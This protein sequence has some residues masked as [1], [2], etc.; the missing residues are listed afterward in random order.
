MLESAKF[1]IERALCFVRSKS[2]LPQPFGKYKSLTRVNF[3][4]DCLPSFK[5]SDLQNCDVN[6]KI[7]R[8]IKNVVNSL[9]FGR[10]WK[11]LNQVTRWGQ[12]PESSRIGNIMFRFTFAIV[13]K[14][15]ETAIS[16]TIWSTCLVIKL[17]VITD[18]GAIIIGA[19]IEASFV[20]LRSVYAVNR[21]YFHAFATVTLFID[22]S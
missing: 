6:K 3:P 12:Q 21:H 4:F 13:I 16:N 7:F 5:S 14:I 9:R 2:K 11:N 17:S 1:C 19:L 18:L 8:S 20:V 22:C 10:D 15:A